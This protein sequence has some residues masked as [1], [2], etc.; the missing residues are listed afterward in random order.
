MMNTPTPVAILA[1]QVSVAQQVDATVAVIALTEQSYLSPA[2]AAELA[3]LIIDNTDSRART[4]T[5][6]IT[7]NIVF[8]VLA[9]AILIMTIFMSR[10]IGMRRSRRAHPAHPEAEKAPASFGGKHQVFISS[11]DRDRDWVDMLVNQLD[12]EGFEVWWYAKDA[13][14]KP[15]GDEIVRAIF[16]AK[17]FVVIISPDSMGSKH[18]EEEIRIADRY[19]KPIINILY[20]N[21]ERR[22]YGLAKGSEIDF[23]DDIEGDI[24]YEEKQ[25]A[26]MGFLL[27]AIDY[28]LGLKTADKEATGEAAN[29]TDESASNTKGGDES[30]PNL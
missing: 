9:A 1:T 25:Q 14:G 19:D 11:S 10:G 12:G 29:T 22:L 20:R 30:A 3:G 2:E 8:T 15:F 5:L 13:L 24:S 4:Q 23:T 21:T 26:A 17:V 28:H 16:T 7:L 27:G 6:L 18:V